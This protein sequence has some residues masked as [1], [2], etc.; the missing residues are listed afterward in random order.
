MKQSYC[1]VYVKTQQI[2]A[3]FSVSKEFT[4]NLA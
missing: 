1:K 3:E 4:I 2:P